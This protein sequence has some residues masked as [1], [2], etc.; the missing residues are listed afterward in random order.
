VGLLGVGLG[1]RTEWRGLWSDVAAG[2]P[3]GRSGSPRPFAD[4]V[5][6]G[7]LYV[8][9]IPEEVPVRWG[10]FSSAVS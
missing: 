3:A 4:L 5:F 10:S 7:S 6:S 9:V 2:L 8:D 1:H